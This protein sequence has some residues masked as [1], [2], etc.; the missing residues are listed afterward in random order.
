M[1]MHR[2]DIQGILDNV[3]KIEVKIADLK[4]ENA[5]IRDFCMK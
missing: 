2:K 1:K 3:A 5:R 4:K